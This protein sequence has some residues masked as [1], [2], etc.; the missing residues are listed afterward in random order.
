MSNTFKEPLTVLQVRLAKKEGVTLAF[1]NVQVAGLIQLHGIKINKAQD[2]R[3]YIAMPGQK[4]I[5][6]KKEVLDEEGK[7]IYDNPFYPSSVDARNILTS[8]VLN[9]YAA[10]VAEAKAKIASA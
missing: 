1:A 9:A 2:G 6:D 10:K 3:L 7:V 4:R 5:K 8:A